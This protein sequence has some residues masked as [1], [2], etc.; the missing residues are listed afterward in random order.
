[1]GLF[2]LTGKV[3]VVTGG[4]SGLGQGMAIGFAE[5]G[6]DIV[7]ISYTDSDETVKA[8]ENLG[9]KA[10]QIKADLSDET[11]LEHV[12]NEAL[13]FFGR[14]DILVNNAGII[15]RVPAVD[16]PAKDWHDVINLNLNTVFF[17]CQLAGKH[18]IERGSGKIINVASM[19]SYQGGINVPGYT[20]SKHA[21]A[22]ITKSFANEWAS[23][24]IQ[25]NA[26][27]PGYMATDN[28]SALRAD[29]GRSKDILAR[30]PASRWGTP[31]DL[32]GPAVFLA[33]EA[34]D[35]LNGHVVCVDGGWMAR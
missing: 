1:M 3:A 4:G 14:V 2:D 24:G 11:V 22:G 23:K 21:V 6:A 28:T 32:K 15:R 20:A 17:L 9:R 33:S 25:I 31:A 5:A 18:M 34:S 7:S 29:E 19:L 10:R 35:Y 8:V 12:F 26:I 30:I 27:A 13:G 16:H